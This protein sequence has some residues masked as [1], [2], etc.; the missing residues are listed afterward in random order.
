MMERPTHPWP[1]EFAELLAGLHPNPD[2]PGC[3]GVEVDVSAEQLK[4][5][6][7]FEAAVRHRC[8]RL[9]KPGDSRALVGEMNPL[10]GLGAPADP[11]RHDARIRISFHDVAAE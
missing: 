3:Y 10:V 2:Q 5:L 1:A 7:L 4:G 11:R 9:A 8:V 6:A